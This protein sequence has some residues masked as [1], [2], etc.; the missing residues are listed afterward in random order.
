MRKIPA[1]LCVRC[2]GNKHLCGLSSCPIV[3]RF[4]T[5]VN[6]TLKVSAK[7]SIDGSTPPSV[8]VGESSYPR[9][10]LL[11]NVPPGVSGEDAREYENPKDW[12]GKRSIYEIL[13]LRSSMISNVLKTKVDD[14][15]KLYEREISL[16]T[17]SENPVLSMSKVNGE[18]KPS[19]K[20]D[21]YLMPRGPSINSADIKVI[22]NPKLSRLMEKMI[23][24]DVKASQ[25]VIELYKN[26]HDLYKIINALSMGLLG[27]KKSRKLVPTRWAITAVDSVV[28]KD[29]LSKVREYDS[30]NEVEVY[31]QQYLGNIFH[32][33]LY[34][35][36]Y[37]VAWIEIWHP[38]SLWSNELVISELS[39]NYWGVYDF[40]DGGYMAARLAVLES[41]ENRKRSAGVIIVREITKDYFAPLGNWHIRETVRRAMQN[42][43]A[44]LDSLSKGIEFVESRLSKGVNLK[45][46]KS[47]NGILTQ[48]T[49]DSFLDYQGKH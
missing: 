1:E 34:P 9:V 37:R 20:F 12:W 27:R 31:F 22:E 6:I 2:K 15:W 26:N 36:S 10:S 19:L 28:G 5:I 11:F 40:M 33:I 38:L 17:V 46:L 18:I 25:G 8:V 24:D 48:R 32:V 39:E 13:N 43:I 44:T 7:E 29:L 16:T 47:V 21:G 49:I 4:R 3:E 45:S 41:L 23:F 42:K 14:V 30:I 35:S